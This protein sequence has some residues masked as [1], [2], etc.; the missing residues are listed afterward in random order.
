MST[1]GVRDPVPAPA[2]WSRLA[3]RLRQPIATDSLVAFRVGF[4]LLQLVA[5]ARFFAHDWIDKYTQEPGVFFHYYGFGWVRPLPAP[6]MHLHYAAMGALCILLAL[7]L[8]TRVSAALFGAA[9]VYAHLIDKT[10]YLNHYYLVALLA[11]LSALLPLGRA[12][13]LDVRLR[14]ERRL[15]T[16]PAWTLGVLRAQIGLVY[17]FGGIAKLKPD[18]LLHAQPMKIWLSANPDF[19]LLGPFFDDE[20]LAHVFSWTGA[21]FD[22]TIVPLLLWRRSRPFAYGAVVLFHLMTARL[23]S[24]GMFPYIMIVA[25]LVFF[26]ADWPRGLWRFLTGARTATAEVPQPAPPGRPVML[27]LAVHFLIQLVLPFR[28]LLY[29]GNVVWTEEGFRF[30]WNVML[31]EKNGSAEFRVTDPDSGRTWTVHPRAILTD[32]QAKMMATQPDMLLEFAHQLAARFRAR[33]IARPEVRADAFASLNG[34]P[35]ERLVDPA[36]DLARERD[37]FGSKPWILP[38]TGADPP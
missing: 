7:G 17:L 20:W 15:R 12:F 9:F 11:G 28:H 24:L 30:A 34:R 27:C 14:P 32:Q 2:W 29:P 5:V 35:L 22:L 4:G 23:F 26:P 1:A 19:P 37:G 25:T 33:G 21:L 18:W 36:V 3:G 6:L 8:H 16:F 13:S 31:M 38:F 10:N